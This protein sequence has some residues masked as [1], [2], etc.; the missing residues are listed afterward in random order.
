MGDSM[1]LANRILVL[2]LN[3]A[4]ADELS[5]IEGNYLFIRVTNL[6]KLQAINKKYDCLII[7]ESELKNFSPILANFEPKKVFIVT[8][9]EAFDEFTVLKRPLRAMNIQGTL[10]TQLGEFRLP[11]RDTGLIQKGSI[12]KNKLFPEWG[13]GHVQ[14]DLGD[15]NFTIKFTH[16]EKLMKKAEITCHKSLLRIICTIQEFT[17]ENR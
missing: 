7:A 12:V 14:E 9:K 13:L 6:E 2:G 8:E 3:T 4:E 15:G 1:I 10:D 5:K 11:P 16:T 17:Y